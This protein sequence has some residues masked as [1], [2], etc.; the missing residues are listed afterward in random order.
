MNNIFPEKAWEDYIYWQMNDKAM[1]KRINEL[2]K[3]INRNGISN[4]IEKPEPLK[5]RKAWSRRINYE[6]RLVYNIDANK[7]LIIISCRGHYEN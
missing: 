4:G 2:L 7:N 5:Y 1:L 3:D 6:H